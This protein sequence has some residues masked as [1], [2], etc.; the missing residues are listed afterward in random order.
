MG[1]L[2]N[3]SSLYRYVLIGFCGLSDKKAGTPKLLLALA[4]SLL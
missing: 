2:V 4:L 1:Q 3:C